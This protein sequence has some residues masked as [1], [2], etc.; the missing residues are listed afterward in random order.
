MQ[1]SKQIQRLNQKEK[2]LRKELVRLTESLKLENADL[3]ADVLNHLGM[4][5]VDSKSLAGAILQLQA[6]SHD[7][8]KKRLQALASEGE[9]LLRKMKRRK[10]L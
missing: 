10:S 7:N 6:F 4:N 5:D 2:T 8:D 9:S 3:V 1:A